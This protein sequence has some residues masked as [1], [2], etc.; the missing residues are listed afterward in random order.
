MENWYYKVKLY[1][2]FVCIKKGYLYIGCIIV[3]IYYFF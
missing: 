1:N 3:Y 2:K